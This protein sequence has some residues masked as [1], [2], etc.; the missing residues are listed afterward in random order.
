MLRVFLIAD[1]HYFSPQIYEPDSRAYL[2]REQGDQICL[3]ES[4]AI[5]DA[6]FDFMAQCGDTDIILIPGDLI[7]CGEKI[8]HMEF[9]E[10]LQALRRAGKRVYVT[11]ATHDY[12]G[13][14]Y[15]EN[16]FF[17]AMRFSGT[18]PT[19][20]EATHRDDLRSLY[21]EFGPNDALSIHQQSMS[22]CVKLG[23]GIRLLALNDDGNGRSFIGFS[24]DCLHWIFEQIK[25]AKESGDYLFAMS[26]HPLLYPF[27]LLEHIPGYDVIHGGKELAARL[28]DAGIQLF[29][30]AHTHQQNIT[31][32]TSARGN[33]IYDVSTASLVGAG[34]CIRKIQFD[35]GKILISSLLIVH[36]PHWDMEGL[37]Y[38]EYFRKHHFTAV[39]RSFLEAA[40]HDTRKLASMLDVSSRP[41]RL[42]LPLLK[43]PARYF[44]KLT[45]AALAKKSKRYHQ[46]PPEKYGALMQRYVKDAVFQIIEC[47]CSGNPPYHPDTMEYQ[48]LMAYLKKLEHRL[49]MLP[50]PMPKFLAEKPLAEW[51]RPFLYNTRT[52]DDNQLIIARSDQN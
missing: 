23:E 2:L 12:I 8:C 22:Y 50:I 40:A 5:I 44:D 37:T 47:F 51:I 29:L 17:R 32:L 21:A 16:D 48:I 14:G 33:E 13:K 25:A 35:A 39:Y 43:I 38:A 19:P 20:V 41:V 46:I 4:P 11:T 3:K 31:K 49:H 28:A 42:L 9:I 10:R 45:F 6:A 1:P 52:G 7:N 34:A 24:E 18:E 26:H 27:E 15:D 30:T 36:V